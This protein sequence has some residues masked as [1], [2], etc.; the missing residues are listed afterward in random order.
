MRVSPVMA[1]TGFP[2]LSLQNPVMLDAQESLGTQ[3]E[4][5]SHLFEQIHHMIFATG[6]VLG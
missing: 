2:S 4:S 5:G 6:P 3:P 1:R